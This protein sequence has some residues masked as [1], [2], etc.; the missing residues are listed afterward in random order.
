MSGIADVHRH[1]FDWW[2]VP[3]SEPR[4]V[5]TVGCDRMEHMS[6]E[7]VRHNVRCRPMHETVLT[8]RAHGYRSVLPYNRQVHAFMSGLGA[9]SG[10]PDTEKASS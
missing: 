2:R 7:C 3:L 6:P 8:A 10:S 4:V 5:P 9:L 1:L